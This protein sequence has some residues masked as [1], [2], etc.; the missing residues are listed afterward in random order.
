MRLNFQVMTKSAKDEADRRG[1]ICGARQTIKAAPNTHCPDPNTPKPRRSRDP[2][3]FR[4]CPV[5]G[6]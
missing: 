6:V 1:A 2:R 5:R 4:A 3:A